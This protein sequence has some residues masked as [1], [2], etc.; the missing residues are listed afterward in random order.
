[1]YSIQLLFFFLIII[2]EN[3]NKLKKFVGYSK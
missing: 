2:Q 1:L 3:Y